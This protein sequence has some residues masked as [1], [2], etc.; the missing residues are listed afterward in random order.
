MHMLRISL[1]ALAGLSLQ[2]QAESCFNASEIAKTVG[3][4]FQAAPK[5]QASLIEAGTKEG[6]QIDKEN[7]KSNAYAM[8]SKLA[9][10]KGPVNVCVFVNEHGDLV[11]QVF[12]GDQRHVAGKT[13]LIASKK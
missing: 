10:G 9:V 8:V 1:L 5:I 3:S 11:H 2:A 13:P 4:P 12:R 6:W 7:A